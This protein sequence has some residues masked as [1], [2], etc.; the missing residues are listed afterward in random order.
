MLW[1][2]GALNLDELYRVE[3]LLDDDEGEVSFAGA[4]PGARQRTLCMR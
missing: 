1:D 2:L 3:R 4:Y